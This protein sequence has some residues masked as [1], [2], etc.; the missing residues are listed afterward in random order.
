M[1]TGYTTGK[2]YG[3]GASEMSGEMS[4]HTG[5]AF[6]GEGGG[7]KRRRR[8]TLNDRVKMQEEQQLSNAAGQVLYGY[9]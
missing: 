5:H 3:G 9:K 1:S 4:D 6:D 7:F 2:R 8:M